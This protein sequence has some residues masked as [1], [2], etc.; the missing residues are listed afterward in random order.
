MTA[1][2]SGTP[3]VKKLGIK[4]AHRIVVRNAPENYLQ[5]L[6]DLPRDV[7]LETQ[8]S[9]DHDVIHYFAENQADLLKVFSELKAGLARDGMLW[10]SWIKKSAKIPTD[11]D[12]NIVRSIGLEHGLVDIK[13]CA[14][15]EIWS[16][17]K[18]VYRKEDR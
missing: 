4:P 10:I 12:G 5:E 13:V 6:G 9:E 8:L 17:L 1:G 15:N 7:K 2:Y 3:L 18:F 16:G 11:L 14:V